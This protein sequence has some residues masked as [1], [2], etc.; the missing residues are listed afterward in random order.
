MI[1]GFSAGFFAG[2]LGIGGGFIFVPLLI[3]LYP[4]IGIHSAIATS[5]GFTIFSGF[6]AFLS[7][8]YKYL[9]MKRVLL[10]IFSGSIIGS[11][12]GPHIALLIPENILARCF[13]LIVILPF[14]MKQL[15][16]T[17][18]LS[19]VI[20]AGFGFFVGTAASIFGIGGGVFIVPILTQAFN[21]DIRPSITTSALFVVINSSIATITYAISG[22]VFWKILLF[23]GPAGVI[24]A[25][26]GSRVSHRLSSTWLNIIMMVLIGLVIL[27]MLSMTVS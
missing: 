20:L 17:L 12:L 9:P 14:L 27:K 13:V 10:F 22:I 18:P 3:S 1:V 16:I 25:G 11:I 23:A 24:G 26:L 19:I 8:A 5:C 2:L 15:K 7:H 6:S 21:K 4:Q